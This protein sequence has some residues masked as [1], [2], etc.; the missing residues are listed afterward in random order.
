MNDRIREKTRERFFK[1]QKR[2]D[3]GKDIYSASF[4]SDIALKRGWYTEVLEHTREAINMERAENGL[5][6]L[7]NHDMDKSI[8]R[9]FDIGLREDGKL[10]GSFKFSSD[11]EAQRIK[12]QV[13]EG[14]LTDISI[15]YAIDSE[16]REENDDGAVTYT[17]TMWT[18]LEVSIVSVP[19]DSTVGIGR[20]YQELNEGNTMS[21]NTPNGENNAPGNDG[22][23]NFEGARRAGATEGQLAERQRAA[24]IGALFSEPK[25]Q[26]PV[27][28]GLRN[29]AISQGWSV[30]QTMRKLITV[31]G[32]ENDDGYT[33]AAT[34]QTTE[35]ARN[36]TSV[37]ITEAA[38]DK[39]IRGMQDACDVKFSYGDKEALRSKQQ[40]NQFVGMSFVDMARESLRLMGFKDVYRHDARSIVGFALNPMAIPSGGVRGLVGAGTSVFTSLVENIANKQMQIG[41]EESEETYRQWVRIGSVN[42]FLQESRVDLSGF[43]DLD[44]VPE[45]GEYTHGKMSDGKEY[46]QAKKYGKLFTITREMLV[47]DDL[48]GMARVPR[49][50]GRAADRKVGDLVYNILINNPTMQDGTALFAAGHSNVITSGAAPNVTQLDAMKV[51]MTK[52]KDRDNNSTSSN[53]RMRHLI[54][55]I[56]LETT[57]QILQNAANDPDQASSNKG[58]GGTR[59]NPFANTFTTIADARLDADSA[60]KYYGAASASQTDTIEVAFLN[61]NEAPALE[62]ENGFT[63]DG[64]SYKVRREVGVKAI[65]HR[66]LVRNA[67]A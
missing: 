24:D 46:I 55:P 43:S 20:H 58:G 5:V 50:M 47:N 54:V 49:E 2:N 17:A 3:D 52:Q 1:I 64:V 6:L 34:P 32:N 65:G 8:G 38:E 45:N 56:A 42:S 19:A 40:D 63:V 36:Q 16:R 51:L 9:A 7:H 25:Y 57:A 33:P 29:D 11:S 62:S 35:G 18:P 28:Q 27:Y 53:I 41:V 14:V 48:N 13:D 67:G 61:G 4:S 23:V 39:L 21:K 37:R 59:P 60:V 26:E 12:A 22:V 44:E 66:G 10:G 31:F 15:R 30:E